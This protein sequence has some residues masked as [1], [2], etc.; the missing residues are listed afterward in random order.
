MK[1][2]FMADPKAVLAEYGMDVPEG[3]DVNVVENTE[4]TVH[5]TMPAPPSGV[6]DLSDAELI[7]AAGGSFCWG[8]SACDGP[9]SVC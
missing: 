2:R 4:N 3:M 7:N 9:G 5:I 1:Q 6:M 8:P